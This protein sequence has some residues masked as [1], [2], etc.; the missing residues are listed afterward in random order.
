MWINSWFTPL[1]MTQ[2]IHILI[3]FSYPCYIIGGKINKVDESWMTSF[4]FVV[5]RH[6]IIRLSFSLFSLKNLPP[7]FFFVV[8]HWK[9]HFVWKNRHNQKRSSHAYKYKYKYEYIIVLPPGPIIFIDARSRWQAKRGGKQQR[10]RPIIVERYRYIQSK[11]EKPKKAISLFVFGLV[12]ETHL[13]LLR[14]F[15]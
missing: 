7:L 3:F 12:D 9:K 6:R 13:T 8:F 10:K 5:L 4:S 15:V 2:L 11:F 14:W 1:N